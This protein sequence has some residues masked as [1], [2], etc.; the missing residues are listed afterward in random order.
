MNL[1]FFVIQGMNQIQQRLFDS[2]HD[3]MIGNEH[4]IYHIFV[5]VLRLYAFN[6][7]I[8]V[9]AYSPDQYTSR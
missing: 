4:K 2:P 7:R 1:I 5:V 8:S 6:L 3:H 9:K